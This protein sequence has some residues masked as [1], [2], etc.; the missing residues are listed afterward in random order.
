MDIHLLVEI[1][2][3]FHMEKF[4]VEYYGRSV[5]WLENDAKIGTINKYFIENILNKII[6]HLPFQKSKYL[7]PQIYIYGIK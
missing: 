1:M 7:A 4:I 3:E 5:I 6:G 2:K